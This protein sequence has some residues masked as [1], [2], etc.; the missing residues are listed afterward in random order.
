MTASFCWPLAKIR[1][2]R[3]HA[4]EQLSPPRSG[5]G[6]SRGKGKGENFASFSFTLDYSTGNLEVMHGTPLSIE[7]ALSQEVSIG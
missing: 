5:A 6:G 1:S 7:K 3:T 2:C 4:E